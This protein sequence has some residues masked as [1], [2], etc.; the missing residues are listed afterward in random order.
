MNLEV[1][2]AAREDEIKENAKPEKCNIKHKIPAG[3]KLRPDEANDWKNSH[4]RDHFWKI[5]TVIV[6][7]V[8]VEASSRARKPHAKLYF[9][10]IL[11]NL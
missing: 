6:G 2:E 9:N 7:V 8:P 5:I 4:L 3:D 11:H 1:D 10:C